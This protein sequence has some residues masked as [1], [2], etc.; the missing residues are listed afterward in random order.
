MNEA[1]HRKGSGESAV[2]LCHGF[3]A[4]AADL[5]A[6]ADVFD[7]G[8]MHEW[9]FPEAP[10]SLGALGFPD[11]RAWYP[12]SAEDLR[13][14]VYGGYFAGLAEKDPPGLVESGKRV[15]GLAGDLGIPWK[16]IVLGGFSQ[17]TTVAVEAALGAP[18]P[19]GGLILFSGATIARARWE[20][21]LPRLA[22]TRFFQS[23]GT[24]D[25]ILAL[26]D[27]RALHGLLTG[28]GL[29]G[30]LLVFPGGHTIPEEALLGAREFLSKVVAR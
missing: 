25:A 6:L 21:E 26:E 30:D 14:A 9:L 4:N 18:E 23:H 3:G 1:L 5:S 27:G 8:R 19:P 12:K 17:G 13:L 10:S 22:G 28:A 2:I 29:V 15:R 7:P 11:G 20:Q 24:D 16:N